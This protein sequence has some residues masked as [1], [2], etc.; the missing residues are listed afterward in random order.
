MRRA[1]EKRGKGAKRWPHW[2]CRCSCASSRLRHCFGSKGKLSDSCSAGEACPF[3]MR[4][5]SS[6]SLPSLL[7]CTIGSAASTCTC[8]IWPI[9][10]VF[11][12]S[13]PARCSSSFHCI[14]FPVG[15]SPGGAS[16][17]KNI[18][19]AKTKRCCISMS[20]IWRAAIAAITADPKHHK[21]ERLPR[22]RLTHLREC[23][24][25]AF[26]D[27]HMCQT[28][29]RTR[30]LSASLRFEGARLNNM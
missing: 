1:Q 22:K 6:S 29:S 28:T 7:T 9:S 16:A 11:G 26:S 15:S 30:T 10:T 27:L 2:R 18:R 24:G 4:S 12:M 25:G 5:T 20:G 13:L 14:C 8:A 21:R 17:R 23:I 3:S 19:A